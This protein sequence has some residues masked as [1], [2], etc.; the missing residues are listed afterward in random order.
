MAGD[1]KPEEE[2]YS[3]QSDDIPMEKPDRKDFKGRSGAAAY[4]KAM[5][6]YE[7]QEK[8][9][10]SSETEKKNTYEVAG[11][12]YDSATGRPVEGQDLSGETH[13][14]VITPSSPPVDAPQSVQKQA[15]YDQPDGGQ[16]SPVVLPPKQTPQIPSGGGG[17]NVIPIGSGNV[18]NS[19]YKAQLIGFLYKQG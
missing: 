13:E 7:S 4:A 3:I 16:A 18:L 9:S 5:K 6:D 19:Y 1:V 2:K 14:P 15:S 11:V 17:S 10:D 8:E 12:T